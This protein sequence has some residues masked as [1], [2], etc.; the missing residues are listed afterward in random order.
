MFSSSADGLQYFCYHISCLAAH[1]LEYKLLKHPGGN[2]GLGV[3]TARAM[4]HA[5]AKVILTSRKVEAG[6]KIAQ[7][8]QSSGV[9][10]SFANLLCPTLTP[11]TILQVPRAPSLLHSFCIHVSITPH[12]RHSC[13]TYQFAH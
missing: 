10:V 7:E 8:L 12:S 3:E 2:S 6:Q 11:V 13:Y 4:A 5:G 1:N 9:K